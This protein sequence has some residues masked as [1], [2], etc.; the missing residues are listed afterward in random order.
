M[1]HA[2]DPRICSRINTRL[3]AESGTLKDDMDSHEKISTNLRRN[4]VVGLCLGLAACPAPRTRPEDPGP[5]GEVSET[6]DEACLPKSLQEVPCDEL[7]PPTQRLGPCP[8]STPVDIG[9]LGW[10][11]RELGDGWCAFSWTDSP[12]LLVNLPVPSE[13]DCRV[14]PQ[15]EP[16]TRASFTKE[17]ADGFAQITWGF[18]AGQDAGQVFV[19]WVGAPSVMVAVVDTAAP[20]WAEHTPVMRTDDGRGRHG[21]AMAAI[22]NNM[23]CGPD[24]DSPCTTIVQTL[25]GLPRLRDGTLPQP[26]D[27]VGGFMGRK[28]DLLVGLNAALDAW[29]TTKIETRNEDLKLIINLSVG[30]EHACD[31]ESTILQKWLLD[32]KKDGVLVLAASG[33]RPM[34][35]CVEGPTAPAAWEDSGLLHGITPLDD[36]DQNLTSFRP[37]SNTRLNALG[38]MAVVES[39]G[40][41]HG[42]LSGSSVA[43]AVVSGIAARV[44]AADPS[45]TA[46]EVMAQ[47]WNNGRTRAKRAQYVA[48]Y[49]SLPNPPLQRIA[50]LCSALNMANCSQV[51]LGQLSKSW[52]AEISK[53]P[54]E[55]IEDVNVHPA[56]SS[57]SIECDSCKDPAATPVWV[58][59]QPNIPPCPNCGV[60]TINA[61]LRLDSQFGSERPTTTVIK[62]FND[63]DQSATHTYGQISTLSTTSWT[64]LT[65]SGFATVNGSPVT[66]A[67]V[68]MTF[69]AEGN[70]PSYTVENTITVGIDPT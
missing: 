17:L 1:E 21:R 6:G 56:S 35:S 27:E 47:I 28:S 68:S 16:P 64:T 66:K 52:W 60:K 34:G 29:E 5:G 23:A 25:L 42:P 9:A 26:P 49:P 7:C 12:K 53:T 63:Q 11:T 48:E 43:T 33:N 37:G 10:S 14:D 4:L 62:V 2:S 50:S 55:E 58:V 41:I 36:R 70:N 31:R 20:G 59:P 3:P 61:Y 45:K 32:A 67:E 39:R 69:P 8:S 51:A 15:F 38:F 54:Q 30:W 40:E 46:A 57:T 13:P 18:P 44:W 19:P 24:L 65:N 22:V